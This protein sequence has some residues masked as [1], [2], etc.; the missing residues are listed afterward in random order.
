MHTILKNTL[1]IADLATQ[2][3]E[4]AK[5]CFSKYFEKDFG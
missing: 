1:Q 5:N 3:D 2:Y 4:A